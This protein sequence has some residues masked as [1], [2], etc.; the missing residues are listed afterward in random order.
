M[1]IPEEDKDDF[2][3]NIHEDV[4]EEDKGDEDLRDPNVQFFKS[5]QR[6]S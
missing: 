5:P 2:E 1:P 6:T 4:I 3:D